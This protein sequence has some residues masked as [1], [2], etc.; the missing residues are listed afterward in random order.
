MS[1][2][3]QGNSDQSRHLYGKCTKFMY[4]HVMLTM[5][6]GRSLDGIVEDVGLDSVTVLVGEDA[7]EPESV[8]E[9]DRQYYGYGYGHPRW[10]FR[11]F[12]RLVLPLAAIA[13]LSLLPYV[14]PYPYYPPYYPY[15]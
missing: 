4:H 8:R 5:K 10:R 6:N 9:E 7:S 11:R 12:R 14:S 2:V 1:T 3:S 13:A 15:Y